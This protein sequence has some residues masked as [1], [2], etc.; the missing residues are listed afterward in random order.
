MS[1]K[2]PQPK[3]P[4]T[5]P[6]KC[7][8]CDRTFKRKSGLAVHIK[9]A[10]PETQ[11][12]WA[13]NL[14]YRMGRPALYK[15][16]YADQMIDYFNIDKFEKVTLE[17][18]TRYSAKTGVKV[19]EKEKYKLIPNDLPTFEGFAMKIGVSHQTLLNWA[20]AVEDEAAEIL[21]YRYPDFFGAYNVCKHMQKEFLVDNGLK[22]NMPPASFIFVTKNVTDMTDKQIIETNDAD[23][24]EKEDALDKF[25]DSL[26]D[27]ATSDRGGDS[28]DTPAPADV[29]E[30]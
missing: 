8:Y 13:Q 22:G 5:Q 2:Q 3:K 10:H 6:I 28:Q 11:L 1:V 17:K 27:H 12:S 20:N 14:V 4:E 16:E 24:K 9:T 29:Q 23:Y 15:P 19:S 7:D 25:L 30:G 21:V 18:E 26:R